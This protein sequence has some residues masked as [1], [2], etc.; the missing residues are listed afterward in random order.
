MK[1]IIRQRNQRKINI[2][3]NK[4]KG[5]KLQ[6]VQREFIIKIQKNQLIIRNKLII[7]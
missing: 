1:V 2:N 4:I 5:L 6:V 3:I 7:I